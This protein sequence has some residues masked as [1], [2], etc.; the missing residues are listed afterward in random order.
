MSKLQQNLWRLYQTTVF[1]WR[2]KPLASRSF[3]IITAYNPKGQIL[4][5]AENTLLHGQLQQMLMQSP[6]SLAEI[7]GCAPDDS[8]RELS[9]AID[10]TLLEGLDIATR[11]QQNAIY[12]VAKGELG[13]HGVSLALPAVAL[14]RFCE[15]V[16]KGRR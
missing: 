11:W 1:E 10:C 4:S 12:Y 9:I 7:Y 16:R 6:Y 3:A 2:D 13:L 5:A 8:H 15:R 14:G